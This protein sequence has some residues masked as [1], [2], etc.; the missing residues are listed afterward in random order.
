MATP[1]KV[2]RFDAFIE[3][4][5]PDPK[6]TEELVILQGYIGKSNLNG[7][8]RV[9]ADPELSNFIELPEQD[10][11]YSDPISTEEDPLGGS[12]I[13]VRKTAVFTAGDPSEV[14]RVKSSFLEG[15]IVKAFGD[16]ANAPT[17]V[18]PIVA[19]TFFITC[20]TTHQPKSCCNTKVGT[21]CWPTRTPLTCTITRPSYC[22]P[23]NSLAVPCTHPSKFQPACTNQPT[24][25]TVCTATPLC[26]VRTETCPPSIA[27]CPTKYVGCPSLPGAVC[28]TQTCP[29]NVHCPSIGACPTVG[30][31]TDIITYY[32]QAAAN[33]AATITGYE[34]GFNPYMT[35]Y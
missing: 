23:T 20:Q 16:T 32:R 27:I 6:S 26:N 11:L 17:V 30:C 28:P 15:D 25:G 12:R 31:P 1:R 34:G 13:W 7:H 14:N 21:P 19:P 10:I 35:G 29:T 22:C 2:V 9:Y 24:C 5:R 8:I 3:S 18:L 33:Q 4:V